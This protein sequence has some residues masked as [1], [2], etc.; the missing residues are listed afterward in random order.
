MKVVQV[1]APTDGRPRDREDE[2]E[3]SECQPA[4]EARRAGHLLPGATSPQDDR[5]SMEKDARDGEGRDQLDNHRPR[6]HES[7]EPRPGSGTGARRQAESQEQGVDEHDPE[8]APLEAVERRTG[9]CERRTSA[10]GDREVA[11][12]ETS[13]PRSRQ[14]TG[15]RMPD[16]TRLVIASEPQCDAHEIPDE[17]LRLTIQ[18]SEGGD[19]EGEERRIEIEPA[20]RVRDTIRVA[21]VEEG[22][23][24][25]CE[26]GEVRSVRL[27]LA[28]HDTP[29]ISNINIP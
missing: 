26:D 19:E 5:P 6:Q 23:P 22:G 12:R 4:G 24:G 28:R 11:L 21:T 13:G 9:D 14:G 8:L 3:P 15:H 20:A 2:E 16:P 1:P 18:E 17:H 25:L 10:N 7:S 29:A 27:D